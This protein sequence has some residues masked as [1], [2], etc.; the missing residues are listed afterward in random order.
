MDKQ[1][2]IPAYIRRGPN[3]QARK[4]AFKRWKYEQDAKKPKWR[5]KWLLAAALIGLA[6][7]VMIVGELVASQFNS[8]V[9]S[10]AAMMVFYALAYYLIFKVFAGLEWID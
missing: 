9:T 4:Q 10:V 7:V 6:M 8:L 3:K 2:L 5:S 1:Y